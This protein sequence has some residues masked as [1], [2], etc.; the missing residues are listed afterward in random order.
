MRAS[1]G[2]AASRASTAGAPASQKPARWN[3]QAKAPTVQALSHSTIQ[4]PACA[5]LRSGASPTPR[6]QATASRFRLASSATVAR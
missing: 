3:N 2:R 6:A 4:K 5:S 1:L